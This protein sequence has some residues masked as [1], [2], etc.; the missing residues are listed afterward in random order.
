MG[1]VFLTTACGRKRTLI[2]P[3]ID[4]LGTSA[5][6]SEADIDTD[7]QASDPD[8]GRGRVYC[9]RPFFCLETTGNNFPDRS[10]A[11]RPRRVAP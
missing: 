3:K 5:L 10:S 2:V 11:G 7:M 9:P 4:Q 1:G 8:K 6:P